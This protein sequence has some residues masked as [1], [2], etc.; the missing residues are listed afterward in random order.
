MKSTILIFLTFFMSTCLFS[1]D[2]SL[3]WSET[4]VYS[5][6]VDGFHKY[7]I[8][9]ADNFI[10]SFSGP[11]LKSNKT[12]IICH[13][14]ESMK[15]VGK[16]ELYGY[17]NEQ[18]NKQLKDMTYV[19]TV[20]IDNKLHVFWQTKYNKKSKNA[21]RE[22]YL[23]TYDENLKLIDKL[24][25]IKKNDGDQI[26]GL[27]IMTS[28]GNNATKK[29]NGIVIINAYSGEKKNEPWFFDVDHFDSEMNIISEEEYKFE[30]PN[31]SESP[32][33][34]Y[35]SGFFSF[36]EDGNLY[37][38]TS[39]K[40]STKKGIFKREYKYYSLISVINILEGNMEL[41]VFRDEKKDIYSLRVV[42]KPN[43]N[44]LMGF[45]RDLEK[46]G[47]G[48]RTHGIFSA[49]ID[50]QSGEFE[51]G[52]FT[53]FSKEILDNLF[54]EDTD[55]R[56][57]SRKLSKKKKE[58][59][60]KANE[61]SISY[62][63]V[64]EETAIGPNGELLLVCS[65][66]YNYSVTTCTSSGSGG[67]T[68]TTNYYCNKKNV[69]VFALDPTGE[70]A[71]SRNIDRNITYSG[72]S[73]YDIE[74]VNEGDKH[75]IIYGGNNTMDLE[76]LSKREKKALADR[77]DNFSYA[78]LDPTDES[79]EAKTFKIQQI[80]EKKA[81]QRY[82]NPAQIQVFDNVFYTNSQVSRMKIAPTIGLCAGGL[83]CPPVLVLF[84]ISKEAFQKTTGQL[85]KIEPID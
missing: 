40:E 39:L 14:K 83:V 49:K 9:T 68:C 15:Q 43:G 41:T 71:W 63:Y 80:S 12:A 30:I 52:V 22:V 70:I 33:T 84:F 31:T 11:Y 56:K 38:N 78:V 10:Y 79:L 35:G 50:V 25:S 16:L 59:E 34:T 73:I 21:T 4:K 53:Y 20:I 82:V 76:G 65:T 46:D 69:T 62:N 47:T 6:K 51:E 27:S 2:L 19:K 85:G 26:G 77:S 28:K 24:H 17:K 18:R 5:K 32:S 54:K 72:T 44:Y 64:I 58:K 7:F 3:E 61:E 81:D 48:G 45:F 1:Q 75:F 57:A 60:D 13:N 8:G 36:E 66:M 37:L 29:K 74:M 55:D 23:E 42:S 67:T